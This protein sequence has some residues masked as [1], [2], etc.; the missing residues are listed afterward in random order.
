M[1]SIE[2][3]APAK[4][5]LA[6]HVTGLRGDGY[7]EIDTLV[8]FADVADRIRIT[9]ARE[10]VDPPIALSATGPFGSLLS[11]DRSNL[12]LQAAQFVRTPS[13]DELPSVLIALEKNLPVA[14]GIGGG[15]A[16]A[17]ATLLAARKFWQLDQ[18]FDPA[19]IAATLGAD[20]PMCLES[21]TL[22]ARGIGEKIDL[23]GNVP[24][25][26]AIVVNPGQPILTAAVFDLLQ[27]R[28][29]TDLGHVSAESFQ[30]E[31]LRGLRNDLE[32]PAIAIMP[33]IAEILQEI[34][35]QSG[36][37]LARMSGSGATCFGL[38]ETEDQARQ[39]AAAILEK[40]PPWWCVATRIGS[41]VTE[42]RLGGA[43][44]RNR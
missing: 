21:R 40:H 1:H 19:E 34:D 5:N 20:V 24:P 26:P 8:G 28:E 30:P 43:D 18:P 2:C 37:R 32:A 6:L 23:I 4:I 31:Q 27:N 16:D 38:F 39:A 13:S 15:S 25:M 7:H 42:H 29:N 9:P 41:Q 14:S 35:D 10:T 33:E 11:V 12:V 17:A 36:C 3:L 22:R 44:E